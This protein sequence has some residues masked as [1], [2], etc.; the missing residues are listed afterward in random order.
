MSD[1]GNRLDPVAVYHPDPDIA[2]FIR[3]VLG[4]TSYR[5]GEGL[6][7]N[8]AVRRQPAQLSRTDPDQWIGLLAP[9]SAEFLERYPMHA[10]L[11]V[12]M[13]GF[14]E[15]VGT[16]GVVR[17]EAEDPYTDEDVMVL[18]TLAER[19]ALALADVT[20]RPVRIG[21]VEYEAIFRQSEDGVLFTVPDGRVLAANPAACEILQLSE[22]E[23]CGRGRGGLLMADDPRTKAAIAQRALTGKVRTEVPMIRGNGETFVAE[24]SST[25][26]STSEGELR[27]SVIFRDVT[28]RVR[29]QEQLATQHRYLQLLHNVTRDINQAA[30]VASAIEFAL[31]RICAVADW[32][33][34]DA[35]LLTADG[36]LEPTSA[37]YVADPVRFRWF[38]RKIQRSVLSPGEGLAGYVVA[39]KE[40]AWVSDLATDHRFVRRVE[41]RDVPLRS[42]V[43]VPIMSGSEVR[44]VLEVFSDRPRQRDDQLLIVLS[45]LGTQLGRA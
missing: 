25:I 5:I 10:V 16:L 3:A 29:S 12:P 37:W 42:Y 41:L 26:F 34:G 17:I 43:G 18:E 19:A 15:V 23:I 35:M 6:A 14:G 9:Q 31:G 7:G 40:A 13:I 1:D 24:L 8:V 32:P 39:S 38:K 20:H 45:D 33:L 11:I 30:D 2:G 28:S 4:S 21:H 27:A 36:V 22:A 44:G